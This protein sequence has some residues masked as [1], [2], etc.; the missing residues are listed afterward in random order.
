MHGCFFA[1][2]FIFFC[3]C[4]FARIVDLFCLNSIVHDAAIAT[5]VI[6]IVILVLCVRLFVCA[7]GARM[8]TNRELATK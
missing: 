2:R 4:Y 7:R 8:R 5:V 1:V 6:V 3:C